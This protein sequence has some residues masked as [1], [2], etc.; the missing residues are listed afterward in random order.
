MDF[1]N[2]VIVRNTILLYVRMLFQVCISLYTSRVILSVLGVEDFG[3]YNIVGGIVALMGFV[4]V[5]M[6][7]STSR[8]L[9]Y[10]L[11][12]GDEE[13][14]CQ[15]FSSSLQIHL[16][17][18]LLIFLLGETVGLW[19][20]NTRIVIPIERIAA[21][22]WVYQLSLVSAM[23]SFVQVP[24]S[25]SVI[26]HEKMD[27]YAA[28]EILHVSLKLLIVFLLLCI[29]FDRLIVYAILMM[30]VSMCVFCL[31]RFYCTRK[32]HEC[33]LSRN[34]NRNLLLP[35]LKF[36]GWDLYGNG[37]VVAKQQGTNILLNINFGVALNAASGV[38][39]QASSAVSLFVSNITMAM[40]P[41]I[42]KKYATGDIAGMQ[43]LLAMALVVC[44]ILVE[45][46]CVPLYLS[47]EPIM[48]LWLKIV[49]QYATEFC[50]WMLIANSVGVINGL[51]TIVIH[52][53]GRIQL[54]S[55]LG[56]SLYL[57]TIVFAYVAF[58]FIANPIIV[59]VI[60]AVIS[61]IILASNIGISKKLIPEISLRFL[62][63]SVK[64]PLL[65]CAAAIFLSV[66][67]G[68]LLPR[69]FLGFIA[70]SSINFLAVSSMMYLVWFVPKY[71]W[72]PIKWIKC[73][74]I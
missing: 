31:Y 14:L 63:S 19:F 48:E 38:A 28:I 73:H 65:C 67:A 59:Y 61:G 30:L 4:N 23:I 69:N 74:E 37:C 49:P 22:R 40:R 41:P 47:I 25:A 66:Y 52:A 5:A 9:T 39:T 20:V 45:I 26:A 43:N 34:F 70:I 11:G 17:I 35:L 29:P 7:G 68:S 53:T 50:R 62:A 1:T 42:I 46:V 54:L 8:F 44:L 21:S 60:A 58:K 27:S 71:G 18:A 72:N 6:A 16:A 13:Q 15:T 32:F 12:R 33:H 51:F 55:I 3:V 10:N 64:K 56:G 57:S 2:K 36:S 24:Y